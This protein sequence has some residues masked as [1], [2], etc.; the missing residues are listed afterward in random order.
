M[1]LSYAESPLVAAIEDQSGDVGES[2][3]PS[4]TAAQQPPDLVEFTAQMGKLVDTLTVSA[5]THRSN[6]FSPTP[7]ARAGPGF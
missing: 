6:T 7:A 4:E 3:P 2:L 5:R 1:C